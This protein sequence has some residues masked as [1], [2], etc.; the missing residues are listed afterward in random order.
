MT[1]DTACPHCDAPRRTG[2]TFCK[3]CGFDADLGESEDAYLDGVELPQGY[4]KEDPYE[5]A[6]ERPKRGRRTLIVVIATLAVAAALGA[7]AA[8]RAN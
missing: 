8:L 6:P 4:A 5:S 1:D 2:A 3:A 7:A